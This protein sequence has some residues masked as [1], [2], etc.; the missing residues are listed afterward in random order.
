MQ[1]DTE[2]ADALRPSAA[3]HL[4][5]VTAHGSPSQW[6]GSSIRSSGSLKKT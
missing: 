3:V 5:S 4:E 6:D 1:K 2:V